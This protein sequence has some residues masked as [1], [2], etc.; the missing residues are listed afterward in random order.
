MARRDWKKFRPCNLQDAIEGCVEFARERHQMSVDRIADSMGL[1]NKWVLYKW[2]ESAN[3]PSRLI[4]PF[5]AACGATFVT[6]HLAASARKLLID[7]PTGRRSGPGEIVIAQQACHEAI[8]A[9]IEFAAGKRPANETIAAITAGIESL[10][11]ERA[12]VERS[13]QPELPLQ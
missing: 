4:R 8:S 11:R 2:I 10:A 5:E 3:L 6:A 7:L 13:S 9:L 12:E 1:P